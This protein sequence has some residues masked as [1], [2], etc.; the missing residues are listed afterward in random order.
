MPVV[1]FSSPAFMFTHIKVWH[2][3]GTFSDLQ[4]FC[5]RGTPPAPRFHN[6]IDFILSSA[7]KFYKESSLKFEVFLLPTCKHPIQQIKCSRLLKKWFAAAM[8][9]FF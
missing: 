9:P 1:K 4:S 3:L 6:P 2:G 5:N 8:P 7:Y